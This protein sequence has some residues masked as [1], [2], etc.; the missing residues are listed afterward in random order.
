MLHPRYPLLPAEVK[1]PSAL[2]DLIR[3]ESILPATMICIAARY[4]H[5]TGGI[6]SIG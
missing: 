4:G 3:D 5:L 2:S 1:H 6:A